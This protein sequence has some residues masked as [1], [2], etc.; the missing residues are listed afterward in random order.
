MPVFISYRH[1]GRLDAFILNERLLLEGIPTQLVLFDSQGQTFD[2][3]HGG[4]CQQMADATHW[5]GCWAQT[6]LRTGGQPGCWVQ[7]R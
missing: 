2:D 5:I 4:F 3:L 1:A 6:K 7:W